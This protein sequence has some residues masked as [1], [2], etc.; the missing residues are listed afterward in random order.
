MRW[1]GV[2][3][4]KG[5]LEE[6]IF[7]MIGGKLPGCAAGMVVNTKE[8]M[9][10]EPLKYHNYFQELEHPAAGRITYP[11]APFKLSE[12]PWQS[13]RSPLLGE[14]NSDVYC[15]LLGYTSDELIQLKQSGVI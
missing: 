4:Y 6:E 14:H 11:G 2:G 12:T 5:G 7:H 13:G 9:E 3:V 10:M 15:S 1:C 8:I